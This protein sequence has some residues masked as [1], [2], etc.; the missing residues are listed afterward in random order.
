MIIGKIWEA[1]LPKNFRESSV[2]GS[3]LYS[4]SVYIPVHCEERSCHSEE[5]YQI[6]VSIQLKVFNVTTICNHSVTF[7]FYRIRTRNEILTHDFHCY[8]PFL[9]NIL[10]LFCDISVTPSFVVSS[11][12]GTRRTGHLSRTSVRNDSKRRHPSAVRCQRT[13]RQGGAANTLFVNY[14]LY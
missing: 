8:A 7:M 5:L 2:S 10:V 3:Q 4:S 14:L 12:S 6:I 9:R 13:R 11:D 1:N